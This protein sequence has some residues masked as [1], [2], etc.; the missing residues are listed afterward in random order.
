MTAGDDMMSA[1]TGEA[2]VAAAAPEEVAEQ[3]VGV[4]VRKQ[5]MRLEE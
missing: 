2:G 1:A 3:A 5:A 4:S